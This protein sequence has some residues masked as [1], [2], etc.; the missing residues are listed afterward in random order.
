M[1][2]LAHPSWGHLDPSRATFCC[3]AFPRPSIS[4]RAVSVIVGNSVIRG[5]HPE[6][7]MEISLNDGVALNIK[8]ARLTTL[9]LQSTFSME[10]CGCFLKKP[11]MICARFL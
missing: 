1:R 8:L 7:Q 2:M 10:F 9:Q 3:I 4:S 6:G 11:I 5:L